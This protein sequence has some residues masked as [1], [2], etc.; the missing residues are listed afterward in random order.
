MCD[1]MRVSQCLLPDYV[2]FKK[3]KKKVINISN[4]KRLTFCSA[5][6]FVFVPI[7]IDWA[8]KNQQLCRKNDRFSNG[9]F[10]YFRNRIWRRR[11]KKPM[12]DSRW[13]KSSCSFFNVYFIAIALKKKRNMK[14]MSIPNM[15]KQSIDWYSLW[16]DHNF[17]FLFV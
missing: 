9:Q 15:V 3:C 11:R 6:S 10:S 8:K 7:S 16:S 2:F 1:W 4:Q 14:K 17:I 5:T 13:Q 12:D